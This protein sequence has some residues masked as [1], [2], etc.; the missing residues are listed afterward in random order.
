MSD[1]ILYT[2]FR[3][4][5]SVL[6][7]IRFPLYAARYSLYAIRSP[8]YA[9]L[10][11]QNKPNLLND[12]MN[13]SAYKTV[14]YENLRPYSRRKNKPNQT[15]FWLCIS[16]TITINGLLNIIV[17]VAFLSTCGG[18]VLATANRLGALK[19]PLHCNGPKV[20]YIF[21]CDAENKNKKMDS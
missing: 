1:Q 16:Q 17:F 5:F 7:P 10:N 14:H 13:V 4:L 19:N 3:P 15:Q 18:Q 8:L 2:V 11:M 12:E 20:K 21:A 6:C 9:V